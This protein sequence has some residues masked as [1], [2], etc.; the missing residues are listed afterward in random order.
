MKKPSQRTPVRLLSKKGRTQIKLE[1]D[2]YLEIPRK[3]Y[4]NPA[5][6]IFGASLFNVKSIWVSRN[7]DLKEIC[8]IAG[9]S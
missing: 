5:I 1:R 2:S 3:T 9:V 8:R 7:Y 6:H 4:Y